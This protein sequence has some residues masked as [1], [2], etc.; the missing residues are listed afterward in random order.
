MNR[1]MGCLSSRET[2]TLENKGRGTE[3]LIS[4][5]TEKRGAV[6]ETTGNMKNVQENILPIKMIGAKI[7][8]RNKRVLGWT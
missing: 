2:W 5:K 3:N 7:S 1:E 8:R 4:I 6:T